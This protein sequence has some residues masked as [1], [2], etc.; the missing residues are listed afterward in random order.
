M[1]FTTLTNLVL[2]KSQL[3]YK[4]CFFKH[5]FVD[6]QNYKNAQTNRFKPAISFI[7][8]TFLKPFSFNN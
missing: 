2:R 4:I 1:L 7:K 3:V 5:G 8:E 6:S